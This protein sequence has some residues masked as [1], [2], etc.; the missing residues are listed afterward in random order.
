MEG[1]AQG[2]SAQPPQQRATQ[3]EA[4]S[5]GGA[6]EGQTAPEWQAYVAAKK[7]GSTGEHKWQGLEEGCELIQSTNC[8]RAPSNDF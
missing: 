4:G 3:K 5:N 8:Y 7:S 6:G 2:E 1:D